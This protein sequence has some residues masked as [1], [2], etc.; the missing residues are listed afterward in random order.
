MPCRS[1]WAAP[2]FLQLFESQRGVPTGPEQIMITNGGQQALSLLAALLGPGGRVAVET[3]TYPGAL[4][5]FHEAGAVPVPVGFDG[6]EATIQQHRPAFAYVIRTSHNPTGT[7]LSALRR[8]RLADIAATA[9]V[10]LIEDE[11]L[12]D[13]T[14]PGQPPPPPIAISDPA[15]VIGIGSRSKTVWGGLRVG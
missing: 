1:G 5:A 13:L 14:F 2:I 6:F 11:V 12:A 8:R 9:G 3:P 7:T 15:T 4:E 10:N